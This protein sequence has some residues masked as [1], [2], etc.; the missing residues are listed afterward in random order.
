LGFFKAVNYA[1]INKQIESTGTE[2]D[3][4]DGAA[5]SAFYSER[6]GHYLLPYIQEESNDPV[7]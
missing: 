3:D 4:H 2:A 6:D 5:L 1:S 7:S